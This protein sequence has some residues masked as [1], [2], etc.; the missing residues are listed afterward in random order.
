MLGAAL[1]LGACSPPVSY[2]G[3]LLPA[4]LAPHAPP[5]ADA[6][7][8][9]PLSPFDADTLAGGLHLIHADRAVPP[10]AFELVDDSGV[11]HTLA[12]LAGRVVR[13]EL[14]ATWC[15][16]CKAEFPDLQRMHEEWQDDG[17]LVLAVCRNSEPEEFAR[18]VHKDWISFAA[19]D[20]SDDGDFP[21]PIGAFPSTVMLDR[22]GRVRSFWQGWREPKHVEALVKRLLDEPKPGRSG[23]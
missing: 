20:A 9:V 6:A 13:L 23:S 22:A 4:A 8:A 14:W 15:A 19:V 12:T 16:T 21:F 1:A 5:D 3:D 18:A 7:D 2:H 11:R 17:L 10:P